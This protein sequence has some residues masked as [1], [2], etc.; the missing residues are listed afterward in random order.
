MRV[1]PQYL[2]Q[3]LFVQCQDKP[4]FPADVNLSRTSPIPQI[5]LNNRGFLCG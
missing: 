3:G 2:L 5:I 4:R 1:N